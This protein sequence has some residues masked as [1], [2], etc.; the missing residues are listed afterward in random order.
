MISLRQFHRSRRTLALTAIAAAA[1]VLAAV[2]LGWVLTQSAPPR[3]TG[4]QADQALPAV[5]LVDEQGRPTSLAALDGRYVVMAPFLTLCHE[6][7]PITTGA[8]LEMRQAVA[9]AGLSDRVVFVEITVDPE[10][11]SPGRLR[12]YARLT[13]ADW[14]LLT[15]TPADLATLWRF[16]G[17]SYERESV[18]SP[19]P[20]DWWTGQPETY[21]IGH[22][23]AIFFLDTAGHERIAMAGQPDVGGRLD[24]TLTSLLDAQGLQQLQHPSG[25]WTV[26]QALGD[27]GHLLGRTI[28]PPAS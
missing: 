16:L 18:A 23:D 1:V 27:L 9:A 7:C 17:V 25:A 21:D 11:D 6:T 10:R 5:P 3:V 4:V 22:S 13:G 2:S 14:T 12:A 26:P 19:A 20:I 28:P 8:F 24:A 15:G